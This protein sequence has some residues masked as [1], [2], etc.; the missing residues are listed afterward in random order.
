MYV[1][2]RSCA[3]TNGRGHTL[4][5]SE[6]NVADSKYSRHTGFKAHWLPSQRPLA[7]IDIVSRNDEIF[8][9]RCTAGSNQSVF[10]VAPI[11][12]KTTVAGIRSAVPLVLA[13]MSRDSK[14]APP[15]P[16]TTSAPN[17]T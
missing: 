1:L 3:F 9:V 2:H 5:R 13:R 14:R 4:H 15:S 10:G 12:T 16:P 17:R 11:S 7:Q 6:A 8:E